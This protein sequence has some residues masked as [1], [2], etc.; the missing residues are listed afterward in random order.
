MPENVVDG[1]GSA[2]KFIRS[3]TETILTDEKVRTAWEIIAENRL[4]NSRTNRRQHVRH[5][6]DLKARKQ[7]DQYCPK[8]GGELIL[9][10]AAKGTNKGKQFM[11]C[12][13]YPK[14]KGTRDIS[15]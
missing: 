3:Q 4:E 1:A 11:G 15:R 5:V 9:K 14:C 6:E 10:T 12:K 2:L 7:D 13:K 8:C